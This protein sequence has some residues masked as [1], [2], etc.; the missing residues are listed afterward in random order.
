MHYIDFFVI[1]KFCVKQLSIF[2]R[3]VVAASDF[4][5]CTMV[6]CDIGLSLFFLLNTSLI[7]NQSIA[8]I[9]FSE[10]TSCI[11]KH[12]EKL[13]LQLIANTIIGFNNDTMLFGACIKKPLTHCI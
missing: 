1:S 2:E 10:A 6:N 11:Y 13:T 9:F 7:S 12:L 3:T 4:K 8:T 5:N